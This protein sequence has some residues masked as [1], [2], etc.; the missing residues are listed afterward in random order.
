MAQRYLPEIAQGDK[1]ILL[2]DGEPIAHA[3]ARIP[4]PGESRGNLVM[5][6]GR[7]RPL[8]PRDRWLAAQVGP[9][10]RAKGLCSRAR[11]DRRLPHRGQ[12]DEPDRHP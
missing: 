7:G 10:L 9:T 11:R 6:A 5:G 2:I 4:T 3:L 12:R 8:T 1:R